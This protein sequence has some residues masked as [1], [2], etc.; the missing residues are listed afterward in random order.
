MRDKEKWNAYMRRWNSRHKKSVRAANKKWRLSHRGYRNSTMRGGR[1]DRQAW[2]NIQKSKPCF[3]C[4]IQY[5]PYIMQFDHRDPLTKTGRVSATRTI[6][7][8]TEEM[9]KCDIVCANCHA[10]RTQKQRELG[11]IKNIVR[12]KGQ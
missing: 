6:N 4:G 3:D 11:I 1:N 9:K 5:A 7:W 8:L 10:E 12:R 2:L